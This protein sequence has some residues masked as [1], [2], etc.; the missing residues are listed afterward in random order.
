[1]QKDYISRF[2]IKGTS[3]RGNIIQLDESIKKLNNNLKPV[4][5]YEKP[6]FEL[7]TVC[8]MLAA[9]MKFEGALILQIQGKKNLKLMIA[10][11]DHK[12][13]IRGTLKTKDSNTDEDFEN[14]ISDAIFALTVIQKKQKAPYQGIISITSNE[15][16]LIVEHYL[17]Q[18]MQTKSKIYICKTSAGYHG[19]LFQDMP[20]Y[21]VNEKQKSEMVWD[22]IHKFSNENFSGNFYEALKELLP[23]EEIEIYEKHPINFNCSCSDE[24]IRKTISLIN[25]EEI[26][27]SLKNEQLEM[28]CEYCQKKYQIKKTE[29]DFIFAENNQPLN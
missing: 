13:N 5:Q 10:E 26:Y 6:F 27:K 2:T 14:S 17:S 1:M 8:P 28:V 29:I 21:H 3:I 19:I 18:S 11:S 24:K 16:P 7:L 12:F 22:I 9:T 15:I 25:K 23:D 4:S 20:E